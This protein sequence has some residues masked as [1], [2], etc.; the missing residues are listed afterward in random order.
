MKLRDL[1]RRG[2]SKTKDVKRK[3]TIAFPVKIWSGHQEISQGTIECSTKGSGDTIHAVLSSRKNLT[4]GETYT[5]VCR[6]KKSHR[7]WDVV[8]RKVLKENR[9][10]SKYDVEIV[11]TCKFDF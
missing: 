4:K 6:T 5:L 3:S 8:V 2:S 7:E 1:N 9:I 10:D 11:R